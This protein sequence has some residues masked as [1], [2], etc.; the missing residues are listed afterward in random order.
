MSGRPASVARA[1]I[2]PIGA[3][4]LLALMLGLVLG[5]AGTTLGYDYRCY[6]SAAR[7]IV[8]GQPL[9]DNAFSIQVGTCPG[10][11]T[12]PPPFA[13]ALVPLLAFGGAAAT[14]WWLA[15]AGAGL[16]AIALLPVRRDVR[17]LLVVIAAV[18]W[19]FLYSIKLGQVGSLLL[20]LFAIA[21]RWMDRPAVM[22]VAAAIGTLVKV[23]P[24][25]LVLWAATTG[26]LR[27]AAIA[28][29]TIVAVAAVSALAVGPDAWRAYAD[30]LSGLN[31]ALGAEHNV[32]LGAVVRQAGA[33]A[34]F[35][36][37]VQ[38][39]GALAALAA[40]LAAWR[41]AGPVASFQATI[42][43][44]QLVASPLRDHYAVLLLLPVAWLVARGQLWAAVLP[45][46]GW[47]SLAATADGATGTLGALSVPLSFYVALA[48]VVYEGVRES[49]LEHSAT[50]AS[51]APERRGVILRP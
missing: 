38:M 49:R 35:A 33:P 10:T 44:S 21:W 45:L 37:G 28:V 13:L 23:Q 51:P 4:V 12:Y 17:W 5:N 18:D 32:A 46:A 11:Y 50:V 3:C 29:V 2:V 34:D 9:Y 1:S 41:W 16:L 31:G 48:A 14:I 25:L 22:G 24:V 36:T 26:R 15:M 47:L 8:D 27:A 7:Q 20:L 6:E 40:M 30:L 43:A 39:A 19:P 42:L